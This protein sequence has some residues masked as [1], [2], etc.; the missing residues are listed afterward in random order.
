MELEIGCGMNVGKRKKR[1][2]KKLIS[3]FRFHYQNLNDK[4]TTSRGQPKSQGPLCKY[5]RCWLTYKDEGKNH[6]RDVFTINPEWSF[7]I[8]TTPGISMN[9]RED[10]TFGISLPLVGLFHLSFAGERIWKLV[11]KIVGY[12]FDKDTSI[13]LHDNTLW[14]N[15][16]TD[17]GIWEAKKPWWKQ[18]QFRIHFEDLF[19]GKLS[20][21]RKTLDE[22]DTTIPMPEGGYKA[23][24]KIT[25]LQHKRPRWFTKKYIQ[26]LVELEKPIPYPGKGENSWDCGEDGLR[27]MSCPARNFEDAIAET[28]KAVFRNRRRYGGGLEWKS[29]EEKNKDRSKSLL[30]DRPVV[31]K[32]RRN[33]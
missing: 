24:I 22:T 3:K 5:G 33:K 12:G 14:I 1:M 19:F 16:W 32:S 17:S 29:E 11:S 21:D 31:L 7:N 9:F 30:K 10:I 6:Y 27:S 4:Y 26:A 20:Y 25:E 2:L 13:R 8:K 18:R 28:V 23:N 15:I